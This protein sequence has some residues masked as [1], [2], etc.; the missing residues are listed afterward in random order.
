[1]LRD[2][3]CHCSIELVIVKLRPSFTLNGK[4]LSCLQT[5]LL[6]RWN[7]RFEAGSCPSV[8]LENTLYLFLD[9]DAGTWD[10][11]FGS[12]SFDQD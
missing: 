4:Q 8:I 3:A 11:S 1:M 12:W 6:R 10:L 5:V 9:L 7:C 2:W